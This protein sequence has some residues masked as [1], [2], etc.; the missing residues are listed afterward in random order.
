M[1]CCHHQRS[2]SLAG[3][4]PS[5]DGRCDVVLSV[6]S[7]WLRQASKT[8]DRWPAYDGAGQVL[9]TSG[10]D[11]RGAA[12]ALFTT[13]IPARVFRS[14]WSFCCL[15]LVLYCSWCCSVPGAVL[16]LCCGHVFLSVCSHL[17]FL[18][19][20][21]ELAWQLATA[22]ATVRGARR[23]EWLKVDAPSVVLSCAKC[24]WLAMLAMLCSVC[25]V[26][27]RWGR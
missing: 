21:Q 23:Q 10:G 12:A 14:F 19:S 6:G 18:K 25:C 26:T 4:P 2:A 15:F 16:V 22:E 20:G 13:G 17:V 3:I 27:A 7:N 5:W 1:P 11:G 8:V 24:Q 9:L